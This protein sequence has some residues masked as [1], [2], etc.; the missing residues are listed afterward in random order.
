MKKKKKEKNL[1]SKIKSIN[2]KDALKY[3]W[4]EFKDFIYYNRQYLSFILLSCISYLLCM[5]ITMNKFYFGAYFFDVAI[6]ILL[7]S[8]GYAFKVKRQFIYWNVLSI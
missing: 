5:L 3:A 7:G 4:N 6:V 1:I 2:I 8:L